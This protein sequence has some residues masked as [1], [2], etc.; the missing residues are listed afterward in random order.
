MNIIVDGLP[1]EID[2]YAIMPDFRNMMRFEIM[3]HDMT[4]WDEI[5]IALALGLLYPTKKLVDGTPYIDAP[6]DIETAFDGLLW[7]FSRGMSSEDRKAGQAKKIPDAYDF[8]IDADDI[9][10]AFMDV[11]GINLARVP[12]NGLHWWEFLALLWGLPHDN[13]M[14]EKMYIR[15]VDL[16]SIK[17]KHEKQRVQ[18]LR[19]L[20]AIKRNKASHLT[21]EQIEQN[22][23]SWADSILPRKEVSE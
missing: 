22:T 5:K 4:E 17:D 20:Y 7:F 10:S 2:G 16:N 13:A 23:L 8:D 3:L 21:K 1:T 14:R 11:Y 12:L 6:P 19:T 15:T 9:M 18:K